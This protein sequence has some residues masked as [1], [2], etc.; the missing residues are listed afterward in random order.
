MLKDTNQMTYIVAGVD[1]SIRPE[2][3]DSLVP[4]DRSLP[5]WRAVAVMATKHDKAALVGPALTEALGLE[6]IEAV[7]DTDVL[8]TFSGEVER[9]GSPLDTAVAKARMGMAE[10]GVTLGVAS[11]GTIGPSAAMPFLSA[12]R[13]LVVLVDDERGIV[14]AETEVGYDLVAIGVDVG[15]DEDMT[16]HLERAGF[17]AHALV[18]RPTGG[19]APLFKAVRE[20]DTLHRAIEACCEVAASGRA[21]VETD[22]RAHLCPSRRPIIARA[23]RR[24]A[25][26]VGTACPECSSPGFGI[27]RLETGVP[28]AWCGRDTEMVRDRVLGCVAC[29]A[30]LI[31]PVT[32]GTADPG[33][34][35]WCNP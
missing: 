5:Y 10:A 8:G 13:E 14:H 26:R 16:V 6:V 21:R 4:P 24:L 20:L 27:V 30:E 17:P 35:A 23:A 31:E 25:A 9:V 12:A 1:P 15:P 3:A 19:F 34:C 33:R 2:P 22:L 11:E 29:K 28:C 18:V 7:V 32:V